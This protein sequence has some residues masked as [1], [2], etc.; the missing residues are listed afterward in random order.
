MSPDV[1]SSYAD[2]VYCT[3]YKH[4]EIQ[5]SLLLGLPAFC[6]EGRFADVGANDRK[7]KVKVTDDHIKVT[8]GRGK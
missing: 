5:S 6:E 3:F 4:A 1:R 8:S 7:C 2:E